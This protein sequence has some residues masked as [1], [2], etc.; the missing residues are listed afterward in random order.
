MFFL[1]P[2]LASVASAGAGLAGAAATTAAAAAA[3]GG[4]GTLAA[5]AGAGDARGGACGGSSRPR[6]QQGSGTGVSREELRREL[7]AA[8]AKGYEE[9]RRAVMDELKAIEYERGRRSAQSKQ[10]GGE[11]YADTFNGSYARFDKE[12]SSDI[13]LKEI[14]ESQQERR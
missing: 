4:V 6:K 7:E 8:Y 1:L 11:E 2:A 13:G 9:A 5:A 3:S 14:C 12:E 10:K